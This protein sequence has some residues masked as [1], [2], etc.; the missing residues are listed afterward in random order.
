MKQKKQ[1][2]TCAF[3]DIGGV[4]LTDVFR[5]ALDIAQTPAQQVVYIENTPMFVRIA[6]KLGISSILHTDF[7]S[8]CESLSTFGLLKVERTIHEIN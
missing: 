5:L 3:F 1:I 4:M 7:A 6:E 8:T 2:I